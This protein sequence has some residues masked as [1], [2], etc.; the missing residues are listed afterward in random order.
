M[1][2][3]SKMLWKVNK[4]IAMN[5][6][7]IISTILFLSFTTQQIWA[8]SSTLEKL[9]VISEDAPLEL[10][11]MTQHLA[12]H[13]HNEQEITD[14]I[15]YANLINTDLKKSSKENIMFML[16]SEI[17]RGILN[18]QYMKRENGLQISSS[19]ILSIEQKLKANSI[20]YSEFAQW[21][22]NAL[23]ADLA[24]FRTNGLIDSYQNINRTDFQKQQ[25]ASKLKKILSY[26]SPWLAT[27]EKLSPEEF[28]QFCT[29]VGIDILR[30]IAAR[31]YYFGVF[32]N[33][34]QHK[35]EKV[36]FHIPEISFKETITPTLTGPQTKVEEKEQR[37]QEAKNLVQ[38]LN[39]TGEIEGISEKI[40]DELDKIQP[41]QEIDPNSTWI[42]K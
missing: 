35:E 5:L 34:Y 22:A 13:A 40:S 23:L 21:L 4:T 32:A 20:V 27:F 18:N 29:Q 41:A 2:L 25:R 15:G 37:K 8:S 33:S 28:N 12:N 24:E 39:P 6:K 42:P 3:Q 26:I 17:Y 36:I 19:F 9:T 1:T 14:I 16:K 31:T 38:K 10:K 11:L 30:N 7:V